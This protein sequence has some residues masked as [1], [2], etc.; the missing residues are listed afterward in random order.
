MYGIP[1]TVAAREDLYSMSK[2]RKTE[3]EQYG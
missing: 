1:G 2:G 3:E